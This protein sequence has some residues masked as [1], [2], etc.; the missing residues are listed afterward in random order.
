MTDI[1][2]ARVER[3][4]SVAQKRAERIRGGMQSFIATR[5]EIAA[6]YA[7]RDWFT[8]GYASFEAYVESEFSQAR[9]RLS[10]DERREAVAELR[11]AGMSQHAIAST[12]DVGVG[13]VNRDLRTVPFGT[14]PDRITGT[15]GREQSASRSAPKRTQAPGPAEVPPTA[16]LA[17]PEPGPTGSDLTSPEL[18]AKPRPSAPSNPATKPSGDADLEAQLSAASARSAVVRNLNS[19]L[20]YLN[21]VSI[22]P[23]EL[24]EREYGP[25]LDEF[26]QGDLDRAAATMTAIAAMKRGA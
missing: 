15:D 13:T 16:R 14:V 18:P 10:P 12:L 3:A 19:V 2:M 1:A 20:T 5:K 6:A 25:V 22:A 8:L 24:A 26:D 17:D 23:I 7:E 11:R 4:V 21:P 9:L